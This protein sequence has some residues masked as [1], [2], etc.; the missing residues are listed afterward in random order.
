MLFL[1]LLIEPILLPLFRVFLPIRSELPEK[2]LPVFFEPI[3]TEVEPLGDVWFGDPSLGIEALHQRAVLAGVQKRHQGLYQIVLIEHRLDNLH[4]PDRILD[5]IH[6]FVKIVGLSSVLLWEVLRPLLRD[7]VLIVLIPEIVHIV[8]DDIK[9]HLVRLLPRLLRQPLELHFSLFHYRV[10][11]PFENVFFGPQKVPQRAFQS[12]FYEAF[13]IG[14]SK[15]FLGHFIELLAVFFKALDPL[16]EQVCI[17]AIVVQEALFCRFFGLLEGISEDCGCYALVKLNAGVLH[18]SGH[19]RVDDFAHFLVFKR[20][21][22]L[23]ILLIVKKIRVKIVSFYKLLLLFEAEKG[24]R[25]VL[26][27]DNS[28]NMLPKGVHRV[29]LIQILRKRLLFDLRPGS[30]FQKPFP[31]PFFSVHRPF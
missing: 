22:A 28:L 2:S 6:V 24:V 30:P 29:S 14:D 18:A 8:V 4:L 25:D 27:H 31:L 3:P 16:G 13:S 10:L 23:M 7:Q 20:C 5:Q 11:S 19:L 21:H 15:I 1:D 17:V 12:E 9:K 26:V